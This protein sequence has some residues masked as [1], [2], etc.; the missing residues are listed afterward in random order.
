MELPTELLHANGVAEDISEE[1]WRALVRAEVQN[2]PMVDTKAQISEISDNSLAVVP[3]RIPPAPDQAPPDHDVSPDLSLLPTPRPETPTPNTSTPIP[4]AVARVSA[5]VTS[6]KTIDA[7]T[8]NWRDNQQSVR[9]P[10]VVRDT[11]DSVSRI[12][13]VRICLFRACRL[14]KKMVG[15]THV[16]HQTRPKHAHVRCRLERRHG[17][18][19]LKR[20]KSSHRNAVSASTHTFLT[21]NNP[22]S[23]S[24]PTLQLCFV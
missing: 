11:P 20:K 21:P 1:K 6:P 8:Q 12:I 24:S 22:C 23:T 7:M 13:S 5:Q 17:P 15:K 4:I 19:R 2:D 14:H 3:F 10:M 16:R 9:W 18:S